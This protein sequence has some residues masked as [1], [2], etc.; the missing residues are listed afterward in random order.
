VAT[1]YQFPRPG[2]P[3][4]GNVVRFP[5]VRVLQGGASTAARLPPQV[6]V[7]AAVVL[8]VIV[9]AHYG[10]QALWDYQQ[11]R[12]RF[13]QQRR[14]GQLNPPLDGKRPATWQEVKNQHTQTFQAAGRFVMTY[15]NRRTLTFTSPTYDWGPTQTNTSG[16]LTLTVDNVQAY[17]LYPYDA[18]DKV[19][20]GGLMNVG[21]TAIRFKVGGAWGE[22]QSL[23]SVGG[24]GNGGLV[25][26]VKG[27]IQSEVQTLTHSGL[28]LPPALV[29]IHRGPGEYLDPASSAAP[30]AYPPAPLL[31]APLPLPTPAGDPVEQPK[32]NQKPLAPPVPFPPLWTPT[33]P[34]PKPPTQPAPAGTPVTPPD[35]SFPWPGSG[36]VGGPGQAPRPDFQGLAQEVG[37]LER[38]LE[39]AFS[40]PKNLGRAMSWEDWWQIISG[41]WNLL[42]SLAD[43]GEYTISSP[44]LPADE[45]GGVNDPL[46]RSWGPSLNFAGGLEKRLDAIAGL[47]QDSKN[48]RQPI[49]Q[50]TNR[51]TG[52]PITT[53]WR[54]TSPSPISGTNLRKLFTY[55]TAGTEELGLHHDHWKDFAWQSGPVQVI[56]QGLPWGQ[57][58][59]WASSEA[60]GKR[61]ISHAA[62]IAG[63]NVSDASHRWIVRHSAA[64][65]MQNVLPMRIDRT[66]NGSLWVTE[67]DG[68]EGPPSIVSH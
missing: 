22:W 62:Q 61:V 3:P 47:L 38:K 27:F 52:R 1:I 11:R 12:R 28:A 45:S 13:L 24:I 67:R 49:C 21:G 7:A 9:A 58:Q 8:G 30:D 50:G 66:R 20:Y 5:V 4:G 42:E 10:Q 19:F 33:V 64:S 6:W 48:L 32:P 65:R 46:T 18:I 39:I 36:P 16:T 25:T 43:A 59:V 57:P 37:K 44:C 23:N 53:R 15:I 35:V 60:E 17:E 40:P 31:P 29:P 2:L 56:S 14:W 68:P 26:T 54:S 34:L 51:P 41:V 55:R 63:V